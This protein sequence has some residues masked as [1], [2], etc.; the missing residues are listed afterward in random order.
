[1]TPDDEDTQ[2]AKANVGRV[3]A[4]RWTLEE[5]I[6]IG[7]IMSV[8]AAVHRRGLRGTVWVEVADDGERRLCVAGDSPHVD[9]RKD[10]PTD[11]GWD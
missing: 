8:Y 2:R 4:G 6:G 3:L 10:R 9:R 5:V 1:M 11:L 7:G